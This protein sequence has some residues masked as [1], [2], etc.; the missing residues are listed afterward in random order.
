MLLLGKWPE[1]M[2]DVLGTFS[3]LLFVDGFLVVLE[4]KL[5]VFLPGK[6]HGQRNLV[7]YSPCSCKELDMTEQLS[8]S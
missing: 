5:A 3:I 2:R 1:Q 4:W 8:T 7:G 6:P